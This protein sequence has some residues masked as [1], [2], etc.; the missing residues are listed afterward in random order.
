MHR[1][2]QISTAIYNGLYA[3]T[4]QVEVIVSENGVQTG[5]VNVYAQA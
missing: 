3:I 1:I 2:I 5:Q 4:W